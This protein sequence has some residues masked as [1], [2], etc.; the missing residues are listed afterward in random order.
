MAASCRAE[1]L[2]T[3]LHEV[4]LPAP[5][6]GLRIAGPAHDLVGAYAIRAQKDDLSP[7]DMPVRSV[8]IPRERLQTAAIR[9]LERDGNSCSHASSPLGIS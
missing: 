5:H 9:R 7:P 3:L 4:L 8:A 6:P 2:I 1:D